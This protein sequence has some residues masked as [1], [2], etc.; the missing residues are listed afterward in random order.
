LLR[1]RHL[2]EARARCD[3]GEISAQQLKEIEDRAILD[4]I[5]KQEAIG[6]NGITDGEFRRGFWHLDFLEQLQGVESYPAGQ[7][8]QFQGGQAK[9]KGLK[10]TAKIE[11]GV[12]PG[13]HPMIEHFKFLKAHVPNKTAK[14]TIPSP[15]VLHYRG[16]QRR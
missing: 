10:V 9:I 15:S 13:V 4:L 12:H 8:I 16:P 1:P 5:A 14:M 6:L 7:S 11:A 3:S 2:R